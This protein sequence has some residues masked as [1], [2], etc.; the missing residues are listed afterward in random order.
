MTMSGNPTTSQTNIPQTNNNSN[1]NYD[2]DVP[3]MY[4]HFVTGG[5]TPNSNETGENIGI[6]DIRGQISVTVTNTPTKAL[7]A[8][9]NISPTS[10]TPAPTPTT[11]VPV[12]QAQESRCHA[13]YR[14]IGFPVISSDMQTYYN[15]GFDIVMGPGITRKITLADKIAIAGKVGAAF[16][17]ISQNREAYSAATAAIFSVPQ[18]VEAGVLALTSGTYGSGSNL[19]IRKFAQP[20]IQNT[21]LDPFDFSPADQTYSVPGNLATES[22][23][24]GNQE[25]FLSQY[26]DNNANTPKL[27]A[28]S[29]KILQRHQHVIVPFMVD[30]RIDFSIWSSESK[31][32]S[33][34]SK[35]IAVPFVPNASYLNVS[36]TATAERPLLEK[37]ITDR[38]SQT[39]DTA[40]AGQAVSA[41]VRYIQNNKS[42]Q[43]V[44]IGNTPIGNIFSNN[45][46]KTS[47]QDAFANYFSIIQ[48]MIKKLVESIRIVHAAQG[49]YYW[50]PIPSTSGPEGGC[51]IRPILVN[52]NVPANLIAVP[53]DS[54]LI[55]NQ[56]QML[57]SS[58][59]TVSANANAI[60][61]RGGFGLPNQTITFDASTSDSLGNHSAQ[62]MDTLSNRRNRKLADAGNA[63]QVIEMIMGEFSGLGLCD[64][65]AIVGSL[66]VMPLTSVLGLLDYDAYSR[67]KTALGNSL[68]SQD[69][70]VLSMNN[71]ASFVNGFYQ[72]MDQVFLDYIGNNALTQ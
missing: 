54:D 32:I 40:N 5:N 12:M 15:P 58:L 23:L 56:L 72:I 1:Q 33:G 71:L 24:V 9:L 10:T 11:T 25:V 52:Q 34:L 2:L 67:A 4:E 64:I 27:D 45:V 59:T 20:F 37:I 22:S 70:I 68:P 48:A 18:S 8:S 55:F 63:L 43:S 36:S 42:I 47:Q 65:I 53:N 66:Y 6:D 14:I 19:N 38:M 29:Y 44:N 7:L 69:G 21:K 62:T 31:T 30:P 3:L 57:V 49:A 28:G 50:L 16:E 17:T 46:F 60:P 35:R 51:T 61:D 41:V 26:M 13:F 39:N